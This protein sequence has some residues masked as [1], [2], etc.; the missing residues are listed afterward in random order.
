[1][2]DRRLDPSGVGHTPLLTR[3]G[4]IDRSVEV[5]GLDL[6]G[7]PGKSPH[8]T[9]A[10]DITV[11]LP[12]R[13]LSPGLRGAW[14]TD[15]MLTSRSASF[16]AVVCITAVKVRKFVPLACPI[17]GGMPVSP[18]AGSRRHLRTPTL[19]ICDRPTLGRV[20]HAARGK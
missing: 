8:P 4:D 12:R 19:G 7:S 13:R 14:I 18:T 5:E 6:F 2:G 11:V 1:M 10:N 20:D 17:M 9:E 3:R 15:P 16:D